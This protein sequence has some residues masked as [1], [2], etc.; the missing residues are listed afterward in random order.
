MSFP[1]TLACLTRIRARSATLN[2]LITLIMSIV[3]IPTPLGSWGSPNSW[4]KLPKVEIHK[5]DGSN[6]VGWVSHME[7][8]FS[9]HDF[10]DDETKLHVGVMYLDQEHWQWWQWHKK[11]YPR[12]PNLNMFTKVVCAHFDRESHYLGPLTKMEQTRSVIDFIIA[13]E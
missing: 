3:I 12:H 11:C 10:R 9:L 7:H 1:N 8:Y 2:P 6:L 4:T 5:F 13:F